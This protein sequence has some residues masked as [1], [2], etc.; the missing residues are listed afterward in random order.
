ML[1]HEF[2]L[3]TIVKLLFLFV[4]L[5]VWI[6]LVVLLVVVAIPAIQ[7]ANRLWT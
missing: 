7:L 6:A 1:D 2:W 3:L 4:I 5:G